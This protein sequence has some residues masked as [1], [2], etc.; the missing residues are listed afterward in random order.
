MKRKLLNIVSF[1]DVHVFHPKTSTHDI[2]YRL[3]RMLPDNQTTAVLDIIFIPGDFFDR[4]VPLNHKDVSEVIVWITNLYRLCAKHDI[5]IRI[6][7]G[8]PSHDR[9][10]PLLFKRLAESI[11][12]DVDVKYVDVLSI[13]HIDRFGIDVMYIPDEWRSNHDDIWLDVNTAL[14]DKGLKQ[15]DY[16]LM[17][18]C[19]EYQVPPNINLPHHVSTRYQSIARKYVLCG[20]IHQQSRKGNILVAG[21]FDR[22]C[23]GDEGAKGLW[24]IEEGGTK[25]RVTFKINKDATIYSTI[26]V[27]GW[28]ISKILDHMTE[29]YQELRDGTH[30]RLLC[31]KGDGCINIVDEL[32][33]IYPSIVFTTKVRTELQDLLAQAAEVEA[34]TYHV[35]EI[36][37]KNINTLIKETIVDQGNAI[38]QST[39]VVLDE[40][41]GL[42]T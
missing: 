26:D 39:D 31:N 22:N 6:L 18:G 38:V 13:E 16:V 28:E 40:L 9:G 3:G 27:T 30:I 32:N 7:E 2:L 20:H 36:T 19:F 34:E 5:V 10:Q 35:L 12:L 1:S 42:I 21:S 4:I 8:T 25:D 15:V 14:A 17:H 37:A 23:H 41:I 33:S 24:R 29:L 11:M